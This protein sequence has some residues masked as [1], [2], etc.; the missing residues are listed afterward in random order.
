MQGQIYDTTASNGL[1]NALIM[2][3]R[4]SD[5]ALVSYTRSNAEGKFLLQNT[6]IDT[7]LIM[8]QH[9]AFGDEEILVVGDKDNSDINFGKIVMPLKTKAIREVVI[10]ANKEAM[11][12]KGDTIVYTA[13][14]FKVKQNA[15]VEDLLKKLP[16]ITVDKNGNI[17]SQGKSVSQVLV[18][19]D[20]FFGADPTMATRNLDAKSVE[21]VQVYEKKD[22]ETA[23]KSETKTII[24][25]KLKD[26]AKKGY[27]GKVSGGTDFDRFYEGTA[28]ANKFTAKKKI[29]VFG[30]STNTPNTGFDYADNDRY[31]MDDDNMTTTEDE[32]GR[33]MSTWTSSGT[34]GFPVS[35]RAGFY[36]AD[37]PS[38]NTKLN[39]NYTF[40]ENQLRTLNTTNS[41]Y[42][43]SDTSYSTSNVDES[44]SRN[45]G[46]SA[47]FKLVQTFDSLS[48]FEIEPRLN[49]SMGSTTRQT[50]NKFFS[51][52]GQETRSTLALNSSENEA[53]SF[54]NKAS[55]RLFSKTKKGRRALIKYN[56]SYNDGKS[57][58][59]L[60]TSNTFAD[61]SFN[62]SIV[63]QTK[64]GNS[65]SVSNTGSVFYQEPL[66][67][68]WYLN[69]SYDVGYSNSYQKKNS[70]NRLGENELLLDPR[71]SNEFESS[72]INNQVQP[73]ISYI[74]KNGSF[75]IKTKFRQSII[76]NDNLVIGANIK[77]TVGNILPSMGFFYQIPKNG[78]NVHFSY[79]TSSNAPGVQQLQPVPDNSNPNF[80]RKGNPNL[81]PTFANTLSINFY[82]Y[83]VLSSNNLSG[84]FRFTSTNH[85]F[86]D[87]TI[88]DNFGRTVSTPV[89]VDG[90][91]NMNGYANASKSFFNKMLSVR[92]NMYFNI[93]KSTDYIN[94]QKNVS[95]S[96]NYNFSLGIGHDGEKFN[97]SVNAD[98][99]LSK[100][101]ATLN[102]LS[103]KP[104]G[105]YGLGGYMTWQLPKG[106]SVETDI[107]NTRNTGRAQGYN[108]NYTIWNAT[109]NKKF[110]KAENL[111]VGVEAH[112]IL[113]QNISTSRDLQT[114]VIVDTRTSVIG[115]YVLLKATYKFNSKSAAANEDEEF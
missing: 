22:D 14:S 39:G 24:D 115:R 75:N 37:K 59:S 3:V 76:R 100:T 44:R 29:S 85:A 32:S 72:R 30:L 89:N 38:I 23:L 98:I 95:K 108:L 50:T 11:Y 34:D 105:T 94:S 56:F 33:T 19:G 109:L 21:S 40:K 28:L 66:S 88:F 101:S 103:N 84:N 45:Q 61:P 81:L 87:S 43:L 64:T 54:S 53:T 18:D 6:P 27:F 106:L 55:L 65:K 77:Q 2:A 51:Q 111:I 17:E 36:Y 110:L 82:R 9:P 80:I 26:D 57:E 5:S 12:F 92:A 35:R 62:D 1:P 91:Y 79:E 86:S 112:D 90:N 67:Q 96:S 104:F 41:Q 58:G 102:S 78:G 60:Y 83:S 71:F 42:F 113:N 114:N 97:A 107:N 7:F 46:H 8:I 52:D 73:G 13:D 69:A 31:G 10:Y 99:G 49:K 70:F 68:K 20:E 15:N 4:I 25:L 16:G 93:Y 74:T 63:D 48:S 47:N